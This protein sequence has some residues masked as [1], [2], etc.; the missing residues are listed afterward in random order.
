MLENFCYYLWS[1]G[2]WTAPFYCWVLD[3]SLAV[4]AAGVFLLR[5]S[6][7]N[8]AFVLVGLV[9]VVALLNYA[10]PS[11]LQFVSYIVGL[12]NQFAS[13]LANYLPWLVEAGA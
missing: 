9:V 3:L 8:L 6:L 12:Y 11:L 1:M 2:Y 5:P 7:K 13:G 10:V 4:T